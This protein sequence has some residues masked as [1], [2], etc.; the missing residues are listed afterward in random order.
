M[1]SIKRLKKD[2]NYLAYELL[3]E[4][5]AY[6]YFHPDMTENKFYD[7][8]TRIVGIRN[9]LISRVNHPETADEINLHEYF[10]QVRN[11][12]TQLIDIMNS[13]ASE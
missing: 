12:M 4:A 13:L 10:G 3:T 8:I 6:R 9:D 7:I 11:D 2:V 1:A 5:F